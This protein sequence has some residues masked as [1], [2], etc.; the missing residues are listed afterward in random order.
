MR[1]R[2]RP[3][4]PWPAPAGAWAARAIQAPLRGVPGALRLA[5]FRTGRVGA[6]PP[7]DRVFSAWRRAAS[8]GQQPLRRDQATERPAW[9]G[10]GPAGRGDTRTEVVHPVRVVERQFLS[11]HAAQA[12]PI[13][14]ALLMPAAVEHGEDVPGHIGDAERAVRQAAAS[15]PRLSTSTS[16]NCRRNVR[17]TGSHPWRSKPIPWI[18]TSHGRHQSRV[19]RSS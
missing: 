7:G 13:T 18:R 1:A 11:D 3:W 8:A 9:V 17:S 14:W 2:T 19:P 10:K 5:P 16:R 6:A 12:Y 15:A 4:R